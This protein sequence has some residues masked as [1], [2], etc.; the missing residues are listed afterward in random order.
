MDKDRVS[1]EQ[2]ALLL[3]LVI[4][5]GKFLSLPSILAS[6]VGHDSW[7]V[8]CFSFLWDFICLCFL[9]WAIKLN[10]N[11]KLSVDR[12]LSDTLS[13]IGCKVIMAIFFVLYV[14][15]ALVLLSSG[16]R[17]FAVTFDVNTNWIAFVLPVVALCVFCLWRGFNSVARASQLLFG[18]IVISVVALLANALI[19]TKWTQL[20]PI[21]E[22]G[23]GKILKTS[24]LRSFWFSDYIFVYF[25]LDK[26]EVKKHVYLPML[27]VFFAGAL[28]TLL[29]NA[30]FVSIYGSYAPLADLAMSKVGIFSLGE[31]ASGRWD[32]LTLSVWIMSVILK[33]VVFFYCAYKSAEKIFEFSPSKINLITVVVLTMLMLTPMF[34]SSEQFVEKF[35]N[36]CIVPF[37]AVQFALP[38]VYPFLLNAAKRKQEK[39]LQ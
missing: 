18:L 37:S 21:A 26:I 11:T 31:S 32:W 27:S 33:I 25:L 19:E 29:L 8:M 2:S 16:Y 6:E 34:V 10:K 5:G 9:L 39:K 14:C 15:R 35:V 13:K 12:V 3:M 24:Y 17:M 28:L 30:I 1:I 23:W 7:L 4:A 20:L 22:V 38:L 36:N